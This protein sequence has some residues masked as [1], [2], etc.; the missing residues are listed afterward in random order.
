MGEKWLNADEVADY[1]KI[2]KGT[3]YNYVNVG[4]IPFVKVGARVLFCKEEIDRWLMT[5]G[6]REAAQKILKNPKRVSLVS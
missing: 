4:R 2:A 1:V 3:I 6:D 5:G